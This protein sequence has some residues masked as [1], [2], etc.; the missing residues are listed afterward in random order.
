MIYKSKKIN[1]QE[2]LNEK[3]ENNYLEIN[4]YNELRKKINISALITIGISIILI[5]PAM[6][7]YI[8]IIPITVPF[9][10]LVIS[11]LVGGCLGAI[12]TIPTIIGN[13]G[14]VIM[15]SFLK[16]SNKKIEKTLEQLNN[17]KTNNNQKEII[18]KNSQ[19]SMS[20]EQQ[21]KKN[22]YNYQYNSNYTPN[23]ILPNNNTN[24]KNNNPKRK[25]LK[26]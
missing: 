3:K 5:A 10:P 7:Y 6:L 24:I 11:A 19:P 8:D 23:F 20:K 26:K 21:T 18:Q 12:A 1:R 13:I 22:K 14:I 16:L 25:I 17:E 9:Y 15:I 4:E 2:Y